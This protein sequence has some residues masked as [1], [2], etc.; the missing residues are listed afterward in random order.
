MT[1]LGTCP[2][3]GRDDVRVVAGQL[4]SHHF[5]WP[6]GTDN[7]ARCTGGGKRPVL[8]P[9]VCRTCQQPITRRLLEGH[10][11]LTRRQREVY[12]HVRDLILQ[13]QP[14]PPVRALCRTFE[15][16]STNGIADVMRVIVSKGWLARTT[17]RG[18]YTLPFE[19]VQP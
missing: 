9:I 17:T 16:S 18:S 11:P 5:F 13:G 15:I 1:V 7:V 2:D 3:C 10:E 4:T 6:R 19:D 8:T 12:E 14:C